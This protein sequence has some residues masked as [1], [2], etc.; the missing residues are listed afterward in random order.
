MFFLSAN[1]LIN[2]VFLP[3]SPPLWLVMA[4][5]SLLFA[6]LNRSVNPERRFIAV[7]SIT[8]PILFLGAIVLITCL[9]NHGIGIRILGNSRYGGKNY[10]YVF[11][12]I[13]G[14]FVLIS[15]R[16][17]TERAGLFSALLFLPGLTGLMPNIIYMLGPVFYPLFS[18]F[19]PEFA[20]E[21]ARGDFSL[22]PSIARVTGISFVGIALYNFLLARYG[23]RGLLDI[24]KPLRF[25]FLLV[26]AACCIVS[27]FRSVLIGFVITFAS[28]FYFEGLHKTRLMVILL[29]FVVLI[30]AIVLPYSEKL[31]LTVQRTISF[32]PVK[33]D[34]I[35]ATSAL[36]S[37][38][39]RLDVWKYAVQHIP[40][41]LI[42]GKGYSISADDWVI[43]GIKSQIESSAEVMLKTGDF[44]NGPLSVIIPFGIFG[45]IAF[46]WFLTASVRYLFH[47]YRFGDS[48]LKVI[49][50][51]LL[52]AFVAKI[53]FFVIVF[54][55]FH[56]D[57]LS[58]MSL[59]GF[60]V[61][62]NG[63]PEPVV[64]EQAT[65]QLAEAFT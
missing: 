5:A 47:N 39:W 58:F 61:S 6:V 31:P 33:V 34:P 28:M 59:V 50:T 19:S 10:F 21:Q 32:L 16:I 4:A 11:A 17:S 27:G 35:V 3:G 45:V 20:A 55:A 49:N 15:E 24:R 26:A 9:L 14:Y 52:A 53:V 54:G 43:L 23:V 38:E 40:H 37:T 7:P 8:K 46:I 1:A 2:P 51:F 36:S 29:A 56:T 22:L 13:A 42:K 62:L 63:P 25:C 48:R 60:G 12:A 57:L 30:S 65:E 44:H 41:Y 18:L 64:E